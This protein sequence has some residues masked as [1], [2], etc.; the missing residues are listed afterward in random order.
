M[1]CF[2]ELPER[3]QYRVEQGVWVKVGVLTSVGNERFWCR[4]IQVTPDR[5]RFLATVDNDPVHISLKCGD[6]IVLQPQHVLQMAN[7]ADMLSFTRLSRRLGPRNGAV[8]WDTA[9]IKAGV[10]IAQKPD[11]THKKI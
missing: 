3:I 6:P 5:T 11:T 10:A 2:E 1:W 7:L 9:C 4:V 8:A